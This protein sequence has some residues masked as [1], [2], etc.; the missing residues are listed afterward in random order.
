MSLT[1]KALGQG[2][3]RPDT[4]VAPAGTQLS[5]QTETL[6]SPGPPVTVLSLAGEIDTST[7][8]TAATVLRAALGQAPGPLV[9][10]LARLTFC[11][12]AGLGLLGEPTATAAG[13]AYVLAGM[14]THLIRVA[15]VS[16]PVG[17]PDHYP[18]AAAA[19]IALRAADDV[20][21]DL[22]CGD[23]RAPSSPLAGRPVPAGSRETPPAARS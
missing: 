2:P 21:P 11:S 7:A 19:V 20:C 17:H 16:W 10:D 5:C 22:L 12:A 9:V 13:H 1:E 14:S 3:A 18:H 8:P 6:S 23:G 4:D 15:G